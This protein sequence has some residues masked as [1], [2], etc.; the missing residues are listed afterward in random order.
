MGEGVSSVVHPLSQVS[1]QYET[2]VFH[3]PKEAVLLCLAE[4]SAS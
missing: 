2:N 1:T 4:A 3:P